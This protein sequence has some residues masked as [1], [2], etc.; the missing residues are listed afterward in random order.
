MSSYLQS[1]HNKQSVKQKYLT[2]LEEHYKQDEIIHGVYWKGGKGC[3]IG[4]TVH[5]DSHQCYEKELG[6]PKW[7][8]SLEDS[9]F[10]GLQNG[11]A[12]EFPLQFLKA[13]PLGVTQQQFQTVYHKFCIFI[14][15]D[16]VKT[17]KNEKI[18][19]VVT[20][21]ITLHKNELEN[22]PAESAARSAAW[23][24][25]RSAAWSAAESAAWS[26]VRFAARSA[27]ESAAESA[28]WSAV[29]SAAESAAWSAAFSKM[30]DKLL[31]LLQESNK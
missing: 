28:A 4:C 13:I 5:S 24:A 9:I 8:A 31:L 29:R 18:I 19:K 17:E 20:D 12:K 11:K 25:V 26:A 30:A 1:F 14:L 16:I 6:I 22:K 2:R 10:E 27:A 21:V 3:A 7:L 23:S 15:E